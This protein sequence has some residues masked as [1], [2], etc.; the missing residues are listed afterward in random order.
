MW[1]KN[2]T[3]RL[4]PQ[5]GPS[6]THFQILLKTLLCLIF[7][8]L[9]SLPSEKMIKETIVMLFQRLFLLYDIFTNKFFLR[10][11]SITK[12][13]TIVCIEIKTHQHRVYHTW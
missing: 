1:S 5:R 8:L 3:L 12:N 6:L 13:T 7:P 4:T 9:L 11:L 2:K 10:A